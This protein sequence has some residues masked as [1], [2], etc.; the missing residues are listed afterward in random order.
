M[1]GETVNEKK[2]LFVE[3]SW[4]RPTKICALFDLLLAIICYIISLASDN[5]VIEEYDNPESDGKR[6]WVG[7]WKHCY[8]LQSARNLLEASCSMNKLKKTEDGQESTSLNHHCSD[9]RDELAEKLAKYGTSATECIPV[10]EELPWT[11]GATLSTGFIMITKY[12]LLLC[13]LSA[14]ICFVVGILIYMK[15]DKKKGNLTHIYKILGLVLFITFCVNIACIVIFSIGF[16]G[17]A[18]H[19][20]EFWVFWTGYG[21]CF[22]ASILVLIA[23]VLFF[24][25]S[26]WKKTGALYRKTIPI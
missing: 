12:L 13:F 23:S 14:I 21:F 22:A 1:T 9:R 4:I 2:T 10:S 18:P 20:S 16:C 11:H 5:W 6:Y 3:V 24:F 19:S 17:S 8:E 7:L 26:K 25:G 15:N